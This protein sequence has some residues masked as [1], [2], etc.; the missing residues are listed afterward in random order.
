MEAKHT[1]G[2]AKPEEVLERH[3]PQLQHNMAVTG[4]QQA[5]LSVIFGNTSSRSSRSPPTGSTRSSCSDAEQ[6]FWTCVRSGSSQPPSSRLCPSIGT[7]D[8]PRGQQCLASAAFDWLEH[9]AA[10]KSMP[11]LRIDQ[12]AHRRG[13]V[14]S[15]LGH[16][17][18]AKRSKS[19][20]ICIKEL[21]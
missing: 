16:G 4:Y 3:M 7:R 19:G 13:C 6:R 17:I 9:R 8:L 20:A 21:A 18:E 1:S 14:A 10:A 11:R 2:F 12:A 15:F 5:T